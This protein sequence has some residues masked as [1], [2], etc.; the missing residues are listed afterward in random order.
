MVWWLFVLYGLVVICFLL[1]T[2]RFEKYVYIE[3][4]CIYLESA[5]SIKTFK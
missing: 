4:N 3:A 2:L 5:Y 1:S